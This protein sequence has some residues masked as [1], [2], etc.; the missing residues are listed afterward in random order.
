MKAFISF[1]GAD[2]VLTAPSK[3]SCNSRTRCVAIRHIRR[4]WGL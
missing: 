3:G 4:A 1:C 2:R